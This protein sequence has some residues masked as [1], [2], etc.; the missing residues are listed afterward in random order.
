MTDVLV[1][2]VKSLIDSVEV[3]GDAVWM[4]AEILGDA[5]FDACGQCLKSNAIHASLRII[6]LQIPAGLCT[7][8][9]VRRPYEFEVTK[10]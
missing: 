7:P 3:F 1:C 10:E 6:C 5:V 8:G 9:M 2:H 4:I